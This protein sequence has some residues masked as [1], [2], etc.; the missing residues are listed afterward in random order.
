[1]TDLARRAEACA[2]FRWMPGMAWFE[3]SNAEGWHGR[4]GAHQ[5]FI[6]SDEYSADMAPDD[7][8]P[9][10]D[11]P[12]TLGCLLALVR[13]AWRDPSVHVYKSLVRWWVLSEDGDNLL[14]QN[15]ERVVIAG[16]TEAEALVAALDAAPQ[17]K[18]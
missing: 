16:S 4:W 7:P 9:D 17:V 1:M 2:G 10:L 11:D 5:G 8:L 15:G 3:S 6:D 18:P 13:E 12:A 14:D